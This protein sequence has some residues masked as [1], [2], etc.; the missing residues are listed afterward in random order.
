VST[1]DLAFITREKRKPKNSNA[2]RAV[3]KRENMSV[4][5]NKKPKRAATIELTD[6]T[7]TIIE[8]AVDWSPHNK[9][10]A[11]NQI[12][13]WFGT[14]DQDTQGAI[15]GAVPASRRPDFARLILERMAQAEPASAG[16]SD[17]P[18]T[19]PITPRP[20]TSPGTKPRK[21]A[22]KKRGQDESRGG[23]NP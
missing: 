4:P 5:S 7:H 16:G 17:Q 9:K 2:L 10:S 12:L 11:V 15:L 8:R 1:R 3:K 20:K 19:F 14:L 23:K 13:V 18:T 22:A 21:R 6:E